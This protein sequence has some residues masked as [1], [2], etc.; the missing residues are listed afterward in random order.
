MKSI[1]HQKAIE[2]IAKHAWTLLV[3]D[4]DGLIVEAIGLTSSPSLGWEE[5]HKSHFA[6]CGVRYVPQ[7][8]MT[9]GELEQIVN[10]VVNAIRLFKEYKKGL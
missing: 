7:K 4:C 9:L 8:G 3:I 10:E 6:G 5:Q 1:T 2:T